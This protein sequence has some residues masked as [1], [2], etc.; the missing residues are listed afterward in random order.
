MKHKI[1]LFI[2]PHFALFALYSCITSNTTMIGSWANPERQ[3]DKQYHSV[4]IAALTQNTDAKTVLELALAD[5]VKKRN[6]H[7]VKSIDAMLPLFT[8]ENKPS[9]EEMLKVLKDKNCDAIFIVTLLN[10]KTES[11]Y[12]PSTTTSFAPYPMYNYYGGWYNYYGYNYYQVYEP[13]YYTEDKKFYLES[14]LFDIDTETILWSGQSKTT[15]PGSVDD[16]VRDYVKLVVDDL[17]A[18]GVAKKVAK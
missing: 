8:K 14:T 13:G 10:V 1:L 2:L 11:R 3:K 5:E 15:N 16:F 4:Y 9:K 18:K 17:M 12:V 7:A 6:L